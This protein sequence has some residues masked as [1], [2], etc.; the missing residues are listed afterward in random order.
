MKVV[1]YLI[2][3]QQCLLY[4]ASGWPAQYNSYFSINTN[5]FQCESWL[6]TIREIGSSMAFSSHS[7]SGISNLGSSKGGFLG[8]LTFQSMLTVLHLGESAIFGSFGVEDFQ[9]SLEVL[10]EL[11]ISSPSVS[12]CSSSQVSGRTSTGQ[13]RLLILDALLDRG[14]FASHCSQHVG[15]SSS[16]VSNHNRSHQGCLN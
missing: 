3:F 11:H 9:H 1:H 14:S 4:I 6:S 13:F 5:P 16:L 12:L 10:G 8:I 15:R 2:S 7:L